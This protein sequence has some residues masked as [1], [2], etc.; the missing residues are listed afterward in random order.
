MTNTLAFLYLRTQGATKGHAVRKELA[1]VK[2]YMDKVS[3]VAGQNKPTT[4]IDKDAAKRFIKHTL[5]HNP[6][7]KQK[8]NDQQREEEAGKFVDSLLSANPTATPAKSASKRVRSE[9]EEGSSSKAH[10]KSH[11]DGGSAKK[12]SKSPKTP[13]A[14][15]Q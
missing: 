7:L 4:Q 9:K 8:Y 12:S 14:P 10:K 13:K 15:K 5:S 1:R 2:E 3:T 11:K 6:E